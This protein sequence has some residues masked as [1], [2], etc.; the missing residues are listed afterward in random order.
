M[1][2]LVLNSGGLDSTTVV[3]MAIEKVGKENI[4]T[5]SFDFGQKQFIEIQRAKEIANYYRIKQTI[6]KIDLTQIG[7]SAQTDKNIEVPTTTETLENTNANTN[8]V[9]AA[10]LMTQPEIVPVVDTDRDGLT[11]DEEKTLGT[12]PN[13]ADTDNDGLFDREEVKVY[14]TDPLN[15]DTDG[16]SYLDGAEVKSGYN[17]KG[18]GKLLQTGF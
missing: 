3:G 15:P 14:L 5:I 7:G 10:P 12:D 9:P 18:S 4:E 11:D 2:I 8:T 1:K 16:D 6:L 17:P 13:N